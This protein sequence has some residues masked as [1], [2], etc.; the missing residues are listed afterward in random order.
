MCLCTPHPPTC[1]QMLEL[2]PWFMEVACSANTLSSKQACSMLLTAATRTYH[3]HRVQQAAQQTP[4]LRHLAGLATDAAAGRTGS[5]VPP[6]PAGGSMGDDSMTLFAAV[7]TRLLN[8]LSQSSHA[9]ICRYVCR[10]AVNFLA[11]DVCVNVDTLYV[12]TASL[13]GVGRMCVR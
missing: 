13:P 4:G 5:S 12:D 7:A 9:A 6:T 1:H 11:A 10:H 8:C 2:S 3:A